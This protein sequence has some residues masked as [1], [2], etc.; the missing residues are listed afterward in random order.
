MVVRISL[1]SVSKVAVARS[2]ELCFIWL[3]IYKINV[4]SC[5]LDLWVVEEGCANTNKNTHGGDCDLINSSCCC[6][7]KRI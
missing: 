7:T 2:K 3:P 4:R 6:Y 5:A 1:I